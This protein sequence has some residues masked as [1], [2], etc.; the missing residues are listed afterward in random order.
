MKRNTTLMTISLLLLAA[1]APALTYYT[2]SASIRQDPNSGHLWTNGE[3][4]EYVRF[5][6]AGQYRVTVRAFGLSCDGVWPNM[7]LSIDGYPGTTEIAASASAWVNYSFT[8]TFSAGTY[9]VGAYFTN[10]AY[11]AT[12]DRNLGLESV[13]ITPL[14]GQSDPVLSS[15]TVWLA[16]A[17]T[18]ESAVVAATDAAIQ[19]NRVGAGTITVL[20]ANGQPLTNATVH[21]ELLNHD[22]LFGASLAGY[23]TFSTTAMNDLY[24]QKFSGLF[25]YAT[26]PFYWNTIEP[27]QGSIDFPRLDS[28]IGWCAGNGI[29]AKGHSLLW[30]ADG[31]LPA[32]ISGTPSLTLQQEHVTTLMQ[33][34]APYV[35]AWEVVNEPV[36][37]PTYSLSPAHA[38]ARALDPEAAL[39]VNEYGHFYNNLR[40]AY[41]L[42]NAALQAG[43]PCDVVGIQAHAPVEMAFPMGRVQ[44]VLDFYAGLGL[45]IHITEFTPGANG[46]AITGAAWRGTMDET[47]QAAYAEAFYRVCFAHPAVEAVSWWDFSDYG[48]WVPGGGMLRSDLSAKPVYDALMQLIHSEWNTDV[49]G[50]TT[51]GGA[52]SFNGYYGQYRVTVTQNG[53][54]KQVS[55]HLSKDGANALTVALAGPVVT[56]ASSTTKD[57]TP[58][59]SGTVANATSVLVKVNGVSYSAAISGSTWTTTVTTALA[60]GAYDV[61]ATATDA[62]GSAATDKTA[63][64]LVIDTTVPVITLL[65]SSPLTIKLNSTFTDPGATATDNTDGT[66]TSRIT[67]TSTVNTKVV[68][69]YKV[70]Y[71]V[72]DTAGN[73]TSKT[74]TVYVR[75]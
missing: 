52:Y 13:T 25:N 69:T 72:K 37:E 75:R 29:L 60:K 64:E 46:S 51:A 54:T 24:E 71:T 36:N 59:L 74:R 22:F 33:R 53:V 35:S 62:S 38:W 67:K 20:D 61:Q 68:G 32:W 73:S 47:E 40:P 17:E 43:V 10:D 41:D 70:V 15:R 23:E 28:M 44:Q 30:G 56:V 5:L 12:E 2:A 26:I 57:T 34:Y 6:Q 48:A 21:V 45:P 19:Q 65:G 42:V 27:V 58:A 16:D 3:V 7:A 63:G 39:I 31:M 50:Q 4:A 8:Q 66:I 49:Q 1:T 11:S 14:A 55:M 9:T 18:R